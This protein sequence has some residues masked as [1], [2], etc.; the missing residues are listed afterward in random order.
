MA[1]I[2]T[3]EQFGELCLQ[4]LGKPLINIQISPEQLDICIT[5]ALK[6]WADY[7]YDATLRTFMRKQVGSNKL[8]LSTNVAKTFRV[9]EKIT[10]SV[11]NTS[12]HIYAIVEPNIIY[13]EEYLPQIQASEVIAGSS[14]GSTATI[15]SSA[16][17]DDISNGYIIVPEEILSILR[18]LNFSQKTT[19]LS[20]FD[21][22]YQIRLNDLYSMVDSSMVYYAQ[23]KQQLE[24]MDQVLI[25][26]KGIRF[27]RL[28][29]KCF[30]DM[31]W[32]KDVQ[33]GDWL[34]FEAYVGL[35]PD[36]YQDVYNDRV[37]QKLCTS[38]IKRQWGQNLSLYD[39]IVLP[40]GVK[41]NGTKIYS[42]AIVEI[43]NFE[44]E[45]QM[46]YETPPVFMMG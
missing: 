26:K 5:D 45:F 4:K 13:L 24:L 18:V 6:F 15:A 8:V 29:N 37:L 19:D 44:H 31:D 1:R 17:V 46:L 33:N 25:G 39:E 10:T 36:E 16:S 34:I 42:E 28:M 23:V 12:A 20:M 27:N 30:I 32:H 3:R 40:G 22:R 21:I 9:G 2:T 7:H 14:T 43:D 35:N 38:Y 41:L 11:T